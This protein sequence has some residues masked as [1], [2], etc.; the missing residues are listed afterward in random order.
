VP[1]PRL[2]RLVL[3]SVDL[4][5]CIAGTQFRIGSNSSMAWTSEWFCGRQRSLNCYFQLSSCCAEVVAPG[6][7]RSRP[8]VL[9][10]RR[11]PINVAADGFNEFGSAWVMA[12]MTRFLFERLTP[13]TRTEI[14][15]RR[16]QVLPPRAWPTGGNSG[17]GNAGGGAWPRTIG[18]HIRGGDSC[19]KRRFCPQNLT[20]TYF[21]QAVRATTLYRVLL[22]PVAALQTL[23]LSYPSSFL[24]IPKT[25]PCN[26]RR[27]SES[28]MARTGCSSPR[29]TRWRRG[30][31]TRGCSDSTATRKR[32]SAANSRPLSSSRIAW[33]ST[34]C[35]HDSAS[36]SAHKPMC[37]L[38][39]HF[40]PF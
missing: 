23:L 38:E 25:L 11:D 26:C 15:R 4:I 27:G 40:A 5:P 33:R 18:M 14:A 31:V 37:V 6:G 29:T 28:S 30:F 13:A 12:Q 19:H 35:A 7:G 24:P 34:R 1:K 39:W 36:R 32:S 16:N 10:R 2:R 20:A 3:D 8:L 22:A 21:M 9:P 17:G